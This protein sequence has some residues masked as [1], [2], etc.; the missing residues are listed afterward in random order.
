MSS[1][2]GAIDLWWRR[3]RSQSH[4]CLSSRRSRLKITFYW[5]PSAWEVARW[6]ST[7]S[8]H[9][10]SSYLIY[11]HQ[12]HFK[13]SIFR[14]SVLAMSWGRRRYKSIRR[15]PLWSL[16]FWSI[17]SETPFS[18]K[19]NGLLLT[20]N[21]K[22]LHG[23]GEAVSSLQFHANFIYQSPELLNATVTSWTFA[24]RC[25]RSYHA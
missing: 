9:T 3:R 4:L 16:W 7:E 15:G 19:E 22:R 18:T 14:R 1:M 20:D 17:L 10:T 11:L 25:G 23:L 24:A 6:S 21:G 5:L 13:W 12:E 8:W 2:G